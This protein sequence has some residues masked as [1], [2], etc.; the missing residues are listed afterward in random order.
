[1]KSTYQGR[2]ICAIKA[3]Q[4]DGGLRVGLSGCSIASELRAGEDGSGYGSARRSCGT[5]C[6]EECLTGEH[7]V[8]CQLMEGR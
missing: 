2:S 7:R 4:R 3:V 6:A 1:M 8:E 5:G